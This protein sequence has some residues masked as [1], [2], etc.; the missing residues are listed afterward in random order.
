MLYGN[1]SYHRSQN[2]LIPCL[3]IAVL[4]W[5]KLSDS[6]YSKCRE[7]WY[8]WSLTRKHTTVCLMNHLG[9]CILGLKV[10]PQPCGRQKS[11]HMSMFANNALL[12]GGVRVRV[13]IWEQRKIK[14]RW[15]GT[16]KPLM[17][18]LDITQNL[19]LRN[20]S[21]QHFWL[22]SSIHNYLCFSCTALSAKLWVAFWAW[23]VLQRLLGIDYSVV[24]MSC[25]MLLSMCW[26]RGSQHTC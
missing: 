12:G 16:T 8:F 1:S 4:T 14:R 15:K 19:M 13:W 7:V 11:A 25:C 24:V 22:A 18:N 9:K 10:A 17:A 5:E 21:W 6:R 2:S 20:E 23:A 3:L 26:L